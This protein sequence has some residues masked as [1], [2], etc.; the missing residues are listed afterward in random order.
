MY[1]K[2]ET[3]RGKL[4]CRTC[5][6][7]N[8][9]KCLKVY[10]ESSAQYEDPDFNFT[11]EHYIIQCL[12]C[13]TIAFFREYHDEGM[14]D[15]YEDGRVE[16]STDKWVYPEEPNDD[17][18]GLFIYEKRKM[19]YCPKKIFT[20][21]TQVIDALN[22]AHYLLSAVGLRMIVESIC[23]ELDIAQGPRMDGKGIP[24][25]NKDGEDVIIKNLEGKIN[26]L[27]M[28][29][30]ISEAQMFVLHEIRQLGNVSAHELTVPEHTIVL[31]GIGVVEH[32]LIDIFEHPKLI[33]VNKES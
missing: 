11:D 8:N 7:K 31:K 24:V 23:N 27:K 15:Y 21:Y 13:D 28:Q 33:L 18:L 22:M 30:K 10:I 26:Q 16:H 3:I 32:C 1:Q 25:K 20:L 19:S 17:T 14:V 29:G 9:H 6:R 5:K 4:Y 2:N 12:G